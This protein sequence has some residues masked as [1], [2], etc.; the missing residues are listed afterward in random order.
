MPS[1][2]LARAH[3]VSPQTMYEMIINLEKRG[4]LKREKGRENKK[5]LLV[6]LTRQGHKIL[7]LCDRKVDE[8]EPIAFAG[9]NTAHHALL[10]ELLQIVI[11]NTTRDKLAEAANDSEPLP[12][13]RASERK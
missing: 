9:I 1:A 5:Q 13:V 7:D 3:R 6:S 12:S 4:L 2:K 10:R 8:I 11:E